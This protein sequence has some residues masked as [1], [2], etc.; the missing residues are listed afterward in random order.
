MKTN[1]LGKEEYEISSQ[2]KKMK[3]HSASISD[4]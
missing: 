1:G 2:E 3:V 4:Q